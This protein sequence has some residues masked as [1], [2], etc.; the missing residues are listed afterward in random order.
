MKIRQVQIT[1]RNEMNRA[2]YHKHST[3]WNTKFDVISLFYH[4]LHIFLLQNNYH[5]IFCWTVAVLNHKCQ[6]SVLNS[7]SKDLPNCLF[8]YVM[9]IDILHCFGP[10]ILAISPYSSIIV[11]FSNVMKFSLALLKYKQ[12]SFSSYSVTTISF[13]RSLYINIIILWL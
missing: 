5:Q 1:F 12:I 6:K 2:E 7:S 4:R 9:R 3:W 8:W 10:L 13:S 11:Y